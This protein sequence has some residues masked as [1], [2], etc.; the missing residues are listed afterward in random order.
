LFEKAIELDDQFALAYAHIAI[1][2]YFLDRF[3]NVKQHTEAINNYSDKALLYDPTSD[4]CLTSKAL[5]YIENKQYQQALPHLNKALEYNPNS[6][7]VYRM[8]ASFYAFFEPNTKKYLHYA[9]KDVQLDGQGLDSTSASYGYLG[10]S[11]ALVQ[12]GFFDESLKY[13]DRS[14]EYDANNYYAP[15]LRVFVR[16]AKDLNY[17]RTQQLLINLW[18]KD[19]TRLDILQDIGKLYYSQ[20]KYDSAY[21]YYDKFVRAR[22]M[23]NL[24][25]YIDENVKIARVYQ[26]MGEEQKADSL[27]ASYAAHAK[28]TKTPYQSATLAYMH[29]YLGETEEAIEQLKLFSE[30]RNIQYWFMLMRSDPLLKPLEQHPEYDSIVKTI[31]SNFWEDHEEL[32]TELIKQGAL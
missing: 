2:Y 30:S 20:E 3:Q 24:N 9:L 32:K 12:A 6:A 18:E 15:H 1:A 29:A 22:E 31:E 4:V 25:R 14:L 10:L 5:Y 28:E 7:L 17:E 21:F 16:F 27:F 11:N 13:V 26:M 23:Y 8:L 19:S